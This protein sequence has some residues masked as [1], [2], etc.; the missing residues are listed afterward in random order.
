MDEQE[1]QTRECPYCKEEIR[2][3]AIKC[4]HCH[5]FLMPDKPSHGGICP[6]CKEEIK[7]DAIKCKHCGS[8]LLNF[9]PAASYGTHLPYMAGDCENCGNQ[10]VPSFI[11]AAGESVQPPQFRHRLDPTVSSTSSS[12]GGEYGFHHSQDF[13]IPVAA[14]ANTGT[15]TGPKTQRVCFTFWVETCK[16]VA[17]YRPDEFGHYQRYWDQVCW[18]TPYRICVNLPV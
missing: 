18:D 10:D 2:Q 9:S 3:D 8:S 7:E 16:L 14:S 17:R 6:F 1:V 12:G 4:K 5:S 15:G 11:N 13:P